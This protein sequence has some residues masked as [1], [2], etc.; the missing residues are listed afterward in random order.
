M[1]HDNAKIARNPV[2]IPQEG[3]ALL[4][5]NC[6]WRDP[7]RNAGHG[8]TFSDIRHCFVY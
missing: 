7:L 3:R 6:S 4:R 1:E 5:G 8:R 2:E